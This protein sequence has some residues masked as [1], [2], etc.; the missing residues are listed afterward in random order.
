MDGPLIDSMHV[1][2]EQGKEDSNWCS[3]ISGALVVLLGWL[4]QFRALKLL[5]LQV[6][7][8]DSSASSA[9]E[10]GGKLRYNLLEF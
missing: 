9:S 6:V 10:S 7:S 3:T 5:E 2:V 8:S 4:M 1:E